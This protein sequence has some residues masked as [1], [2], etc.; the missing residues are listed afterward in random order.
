MWWPEQSIL[1]KSDIGDESVDI[2]S[3]NLCLGGRRF[4]KKYRSGLK[5]NEVN[6]FLIKVLLLSF[7]SMLIMSWA[8]EAWNTQYL[9]S[10][11]YGKNLDRI[12]AETKPLDCSFLAAPIGYKSCKY[13]P[14]IHESG[15]TVYLRWERSQRW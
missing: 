8:S 12:A 13:E 7:V 15:E 11:R 14:K 1:M 9:L 3:A 2:C 10:V 4:P 5:M 6:Q